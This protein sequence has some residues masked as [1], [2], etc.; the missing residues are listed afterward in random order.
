MYFTYIFIIIMKHSFHLLKFIFINCLCVINSIFKINFDNKIVFFIV[1]IVEH[2][3]TWY[4]HYNH[5]MTLL[6]HT[7]LVSRKSIVTSHTKMQRPTNK[8]Q[9][10]AKNYI[11]LLIWFKYNDELQC[12]V[13][14][15]FQS[16]TTL[17]D[18]HYES[19]LHTHKTIRQ[20]LYS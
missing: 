17:S 3:I 16:F 14:A 1:M 5:Q 10:N 9:N 8:T 12:R 2:F 11:V 13:H 7:T 18:F 19:I 20:Q 6:M 15:M 4:N